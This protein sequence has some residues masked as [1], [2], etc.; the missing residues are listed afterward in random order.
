MLSFQQRNRPD[1]RLLEKPLGAI[2]R[3]AFSFNMGG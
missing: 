1:W 2:A 3:A